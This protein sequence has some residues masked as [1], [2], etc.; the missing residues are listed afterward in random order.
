MGCFFCPVCNE[1]LG[2]NAESHTCDLVQVQKRMQYLQEETVKATRKAESIEN[3]V[4]LI[5]RSL[6]STEEERVTIRTEDLRRLWDA[7]QCQ[8]HEAK[9]ADSFLAQWLATH[10][11]LCEA[12][13]MFRSTKKES[14]LV[15]LRV[16]REVVDKSKVVLGYEDS[17][18]DM[19]PED[20]V[21]D[22]YLTET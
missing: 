21:N 17:T 8:W 13:D 20:L 11:V 3:A 10:S 16:L 4:M 22:T 6:P 1:A 12:Y 7:A 9:T 14:L 18:T 5:L 15:K 2:L 19:T